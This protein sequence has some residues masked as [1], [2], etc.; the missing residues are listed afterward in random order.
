MP[1]LLLSGVFR[2]SRNYKAGSRLPDKSLCANIAFSS[3][4]NLQRCT[5]N[6]MIILSNNWLLHFAALLL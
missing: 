6:K 4:W 1:A 3:Y 5:E 2:N